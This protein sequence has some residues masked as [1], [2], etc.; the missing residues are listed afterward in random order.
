MSLSSLVGLNVSACV[1]R[2]LWNT[3][4]KENGKET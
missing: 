1:D 2:E 4:G 3:G